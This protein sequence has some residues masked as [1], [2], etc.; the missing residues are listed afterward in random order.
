MYEA[1]DFGVFRDEIVLK[2]IVFN[3]YNLGTEVLIIGSRKILYQFV[4]I[5]NYIVFV[6]Y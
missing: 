5:I 2:F 3:I 6:T 4:P 1:L